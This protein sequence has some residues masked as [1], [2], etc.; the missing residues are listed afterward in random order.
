MKSIQEILTAAEATT[1]S[2]TWTGKMIQGKTHT[3]LTFATRQA[4]SLVQCQLEN[5]GAEVRVER[6]AYGEWILTAKY[7]A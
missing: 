5:A 1:T 3:I 7:V 6:S 2:N 4:A